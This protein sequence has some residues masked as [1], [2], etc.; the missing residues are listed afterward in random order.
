MLLFDESK[1]DSQSKRDIAVAIRESNQTFAQSMQQMSQSI[2]IAQGLGRSMEMNLCIT[3]CPSLF[4]RPFVRLLYF[5]YILLM[6][7]IT[8][9]SL[10]YIEPMYFN[11]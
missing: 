4:V 11:A 10:F 8:F 2:F 1:E 6:T 9:I 3:N 5:F 7:R